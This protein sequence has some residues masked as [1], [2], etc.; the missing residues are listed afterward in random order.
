VYA[1]QAWHWVHSADRYEK[2][3]SVLASE[4]T[5]ALFWNVGREWSGALGADNDAVYAEVAPNL[6]GGNH[7]SLDRYLDEL[8][9]VDA[10][11]GITKRIVT[12][13]QRY[14][15]QE[16]MTLLG[17]HSDHRILPEEQ[18]VRLHAAVGDVIDRHGGYVDMTYDT[19]L[20]LATRT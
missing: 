8:A 9:A 1:A 12:W 20:Y 17:T 11:D 18:R 15:S 10:F 16:W 14:S 4:G 5:L 7:W 6:T 2:V 3:A 13:E 19:H